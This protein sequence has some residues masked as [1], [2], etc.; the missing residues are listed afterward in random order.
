[1]TTSTVP[2]S[3]ADSALTTLGSVFDNAFAIFDRLDRLPRDCDA[4][5]AGHVTQSDVRALD[6]W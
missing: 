1:M 3:L 4:Y 5:T 2:F 6:F